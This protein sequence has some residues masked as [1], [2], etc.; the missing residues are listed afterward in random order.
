MD[1]IT[2][3]LAKEVTAKKK[4]TRTFSLNSKEKLQNLSLEK[5]AKWFRTLKVYI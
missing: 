4:K 3:F 2:N 5:V 1:Y